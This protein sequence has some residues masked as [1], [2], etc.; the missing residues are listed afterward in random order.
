MTVLK[1]PSTTFFFF[2]RELPSTTSVT[3]SRYMWISAY[4]CG[5]SAAARTYR[6]RL[7]LLVVRTAR[8]GHWLGS[9]PDSTYIHVYKSPNC[10]FVRTC[11]GARVCNVHRLVCQ[12]ANKSTH[13]TRTGRRFVNGCR[14]LRATPHM[15]SWC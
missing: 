8:T 9:G 13:C 1:L 4:I 7:S 14:W 11:T 3:D 15:V 5:R 12:Q 10:L 6:W 2:L